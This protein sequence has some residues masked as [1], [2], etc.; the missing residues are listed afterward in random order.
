[1]NRRGDLS[2]A[3]CVGL[4]ALADRL[5]HVRGADQGQVAERLREVSDQPLQLGVV[6]LGVEA[7]VVAQPEQPLEVRLRLVDAA[8]VG[9]VLGQP[10]ASEQ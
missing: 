3:G 1:V 9:V 8:D 7:Q 2:L 10:E 6:L 5:D 4:A